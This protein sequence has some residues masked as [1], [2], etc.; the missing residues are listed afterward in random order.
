MGTRVSSPIEVKQKAVDIRLASV[1]MKEIMQKLNINNKTQVKT[2]MRCHKAGYT[3]RF[4]QPVGKQESNTL[5]EF[6]SMLPT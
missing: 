5:T 6:Q 2:W 3:H 4:E 1:P